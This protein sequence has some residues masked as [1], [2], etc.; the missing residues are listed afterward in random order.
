MSG[1]V[2]D[3]GDH[4]VVQFEGL[5][6]VI[7]RSSLDKALMIDIASGDLEPTDYHPHTHVPRLRLAINDQVEQLDEGGQWV[8]EEPY[9][10]TVLDHLA[11]V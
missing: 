2:Q 1:R 11:D 9:E 4:I 6:I 8:K 10:E 7:Q 3:H 5:D